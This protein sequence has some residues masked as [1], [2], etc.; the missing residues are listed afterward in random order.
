[1]RRWLAPEDHVLESLVNSASHL[2]HEREEL[3]CLYIGTHLTRFLRSP[4]KIMSLHGAA[5]CGK[6]VLASVIADYLQRPIAGIT[7]DTLFVP[8]GKFL[9]SL[10]LLAIGSLTN[11]FVQTRGY[12]RKPHS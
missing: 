8:I 6:S 4:H 11:D 7:Y 2:A 12:Q 9:Y 10:S 5:G 1:M 3:T